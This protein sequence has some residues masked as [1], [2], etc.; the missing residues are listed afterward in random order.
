M[1]KN[2][3]QSNQQQDDELAEFV[4]QILSEAPVKDVSMSSED[5][6]L[7]KMQETVLRLKNTMA[8]EQPAVEERQ[9]IGARLE[10]EWP[11]AFP[12]PFQTR[13]KETKN[14]TFST[15]LDGWREFIRR[16]ASQPGR[17]VFACAML[18]LLAVIILPQTITPALP[19]AAK[20]PVN[21]ISL[22]FLGLLL[23]GSI[24]Y[25]WNHRGKL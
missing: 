24:I 22:T 17:L 19:A 20:G 8:Q 23:I 21:V 11:R 12:P 9:R 4:D 3:E 25:W 7:R 18:F 16:P 1:D 14:S 6:A 5:L 13:L 15:I 2:L 10:A